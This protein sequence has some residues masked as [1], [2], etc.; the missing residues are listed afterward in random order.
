MG[1]VRMERTKHPGIYK[2]GS[3][4]VVG[5]SGC[6]LRPGSAGR[7]WSRSAAATWCSTARR[8]GCVFA[9]GSCAASTG[10]R[11][12]ATVAGTFRYRPSWYPSCA[13]TWRSCPR[14]GPTT[15]RFLTRGAG[16]STTPTFG[17]AC[18]PRRSRRRVAAWA[19]FH[20]FRHTFASLHVARGTTLVQ[21]ARLLGHHSP[22]FTLRVYAHLIP[23]D[24]PAPLDLAAEIV[25]SRA[26]DPS[27]SGV[28]DGTVRAVH[29]IA[30][31][32]R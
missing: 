15:S 8:R 1:G 28:R 17:G 4:Y 19:G 9:A 7:S 24:E 16:R 20:A 27:R 32:T 29:P 10:R 5:C 11:S 30:S 2:R 14:A 3:R 25:S 18:S 22:E 23:G 12:R 26:L 13:V 31:R 6:S 21:L